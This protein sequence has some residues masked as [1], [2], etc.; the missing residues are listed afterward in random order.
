MGR[1]NIRTSR[2]CHSETRVIR[3]NI[4]TTGHWRDQVGVRI[5][6]TFHKKHRAP[7]ALPTGNEYADNVSA[8]MAAMADAA[9]LPEA[10]SLTQLYSRSEFVASHVGG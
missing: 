9:P 8:A 1:S 7:R 4:H 3:S 10:G 5:N 2:V 6:G